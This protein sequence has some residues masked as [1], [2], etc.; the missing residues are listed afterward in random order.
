M[1]F[2]TK[3][4]HSGRLGNTKGPYIM[5]AE[6]SPIE[7]FFGQILVAEIERYYISAGVKYG[8]TC[9]ING[10]ARPQ[11]PLPT[12]TDPYQPPST[13]TGRP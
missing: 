1:G 5:R 10:L 7:F 3:I 9:R 6:N 11:H 12:T 8:Q 13:S 4:D 2:L